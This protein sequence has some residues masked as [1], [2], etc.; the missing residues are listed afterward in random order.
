MVID[1]AL[2]NAMESDHLACKIPVRNQTYRFGCDGSS[3]T[4][5]QRG[6]GETGRR[7]ERRRR[8]T[9]TKLRGDE[10]QTPQIIKNRDGREETEIVN[11]CL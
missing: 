2:R 7:K 1:C 8:I 4:E 10:D 3:G 9:N 5:N 6:V 11:C